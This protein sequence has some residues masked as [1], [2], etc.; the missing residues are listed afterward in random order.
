TEDHLKRLNVN[1]G[2][3]ALGHALG[4]SGSRLVI[5]LM[6]EMERRDVKRGLVSLCV[7][8]GQGMAMMFER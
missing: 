7:G 4:N 8:G 1:G 6:S 5:S 3:I 2:A